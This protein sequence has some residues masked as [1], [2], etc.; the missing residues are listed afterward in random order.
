[1]TRYVVIIVFDTE[2]Q[3]L[4]TMHVYLCTVISNQGAPVRKIPPSA[5]PLPSPSVL[6]VYLLQPGPGNVFV[7]KVSL[8][9]VTYF[10]G[11]NADLLV[12]YQFQVVLGQVVK[13]NTSGIIM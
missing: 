10:W 8:E 5:I 6:R 9:E 7:V 3:L 12:L 2:Q 1:M 13:W 4:R 11:L